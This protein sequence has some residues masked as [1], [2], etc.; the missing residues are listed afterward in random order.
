MHTRRVTS[1]MV[2]RLLA[3][4]FVGIL[5]A[6]CGPPGDLPMCDAS[7]LLAP[8]SLTPGG[9]PS[10]EGVL[11]DSLTPTLSWTYPGTTCRPDSYV[12]TLATSWSGLSSVPEIGIVIGTE[13]TP[14]DPLLPGTTYIWRVAAV[15][16][17]GHRA[18]THN[19]VFRTGPICDEATSRSL[20]V[21]LLLSPADGENLDT[22]NPTLEWDDPT[23]CI[24]AGA[25]IVEIDRTPSFTAPLIGRYDLPY[26][27]VDHPWVD[28]EL[29]P[30]TTY[31]WRVRA[32]LHDYP[33]AHTPY[34][35]PWSFTTPAEGGG[36]CPIG[37]HITPIPGSGIRL[38]PA[39]GAVGGYVYHDECAVP[40]ETPDV[41][42]PGCVFT[43]DGG[44]QANGVLDSGEDGI[45]GVTVHLNGGAC[46]GVSGS[47]EVSEVNGQFMFRSLPGGTYCLWVDSLADGNDAV[48]I[49]GAWTAPPSTTSRVEQEVTLFGDDD[50]RRYN[51]FGWD[52]QF[53]PEP[54]A[55]TP[56]GT[57]FARV[58]QDARCRSGPGVFY[59]LV[60]F[61]A[62]G[63][64]F[65][66]QG[67]NAEG[68]WWWIDRLDGDCWLADS[69]VETQGDTRS[70][71]E[72]QAPPTPTVTP[73]LG[74][75]Q[76]MPNQT[77]QCVVP[78][79]PEVQ[80]PSYC[81]P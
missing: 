21:P 45:G 61:L 73:V 51:G 19:G 8:E 80:N 76:W 63:D 55:V 75:W 67:R 30:C 42:P 79:P 52:Y 54:A 34:S 13:Y 35:Y 33:D 74:C 17:G 72:Q 31:Y 5:L 7:E 10:M 23:P 4:A 25:Y 66:I 41:A 39:H 36:L 56:S 43:A 37:P 57:P 1:S 20:E 44:L 65:P 58:I 40:D 77:N 32:D 2:G 53:L 47:T 49:P 69:V 28:F 24:P 46:P 15:A 81:T 64:S 3:A 78:C 71:P 62:Q 16:P 26:L 9:S 18:W 60:T 11:V 48:L 38:P 27:Y 6:S 59:P 29:E 22:L 14:D 12:L 50:I 68:T 70:V